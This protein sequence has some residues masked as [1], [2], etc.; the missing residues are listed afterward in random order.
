[1]AKEAE[2]QVASVEEVSP[3]EC[4]CAVRNIRGVASLGMVF[5]AEPSRG[6]EVRLTEILWYGRTVAQLDEAHTGK[7]TFAG[8]G[9]DS[10]RPD[11][12]LF[13]PAGGNH[14]P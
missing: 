7:V 10:I 11:D 9:A 6:I 12:V 14:V 4:R 3:T 8:A 2:L 13:S 5:R 1:M